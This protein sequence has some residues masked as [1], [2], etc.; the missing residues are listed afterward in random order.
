LDVL[1]ARSPLGE[2]RHDTYATRSEVATSI[3]L[4]VA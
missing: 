1:D 3:L 2:D 4:P